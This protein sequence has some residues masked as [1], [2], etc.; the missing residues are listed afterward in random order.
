M[1]IFFI[2]VFYECI[3]I[4]LFILPLI[5]IWIFYNFGYFQYELYNIKPNFFPELL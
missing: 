5:S 1:M 4:C 2:A 3:I